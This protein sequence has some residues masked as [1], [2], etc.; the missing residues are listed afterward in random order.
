[1]W[2]GITYA[3]G[4]F[5]AVGKTSTGYPALATSADGVAWSFPSVSSSSA[6]TLMGIT[7]GDGKFVAIGTGGL[8]ID[9]ANA[10]T[11]TTQTINMGGTNGIA[12]GDGKFVAVANSARMAVSTNGGTSWDILQNIGG[13][14][15]WRSITSDGDRFIAVGSVIGTS[16]CP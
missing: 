9:S 8:V 2:Y 16:D 10:T 6:S 7:F 12:Y 1:M 11:W 13:S 14:S 15:S 5:V 3:D 4:K